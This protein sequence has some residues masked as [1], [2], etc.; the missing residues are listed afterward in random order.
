[1]NK[2]VKKNTPVHPAQTVSEAFD[3]IMKSNFSYLTEWEEA[4]H[5]WQTIEG[6]HQMRVALRRMRSALGLFRF[7]I[8]REHTAHWA[9]D[10]RWLANQLGPARDF[11][12]LITE[13]LQPLQHQLPLA[14]IV[15]LLE[16]AESQ[17]E[18]AYV[19]VRAMLCGERYTT[20]KTNFGQWLYLRGWTDGELSPKQR[21]RLA[22][23]ITPIAK[24]ILNKQ[25]LMVLQTGS[26]IDPQIPTEM[27]QL[28][29]TCKKLRY[30]SEFFEPLFMDMEPFIVH[31]K[32]LQDLLGMLNDIAVMQRLLHELL[33]NHTDRDLL[34]CAGA[35]IGWRTH[36]Y[37]QIKD[38]FDHRWHAFAQACV[39]WHDCVEE[40]ATS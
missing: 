31:L 29:I 15:Q 34:L 16:L 14:G 30:A 32:E 6:V 18:A 9:D 26:T 39:P 11:D 37:A 28:R 40:T 36:Q 12:V 3:V 23:E 19:Q 5:S 20:F 13:S 10:M 25:R 38:S 2:K 33:E 1:M 4:A 8:P 35:L 27:H 21:A 17:R 24:K 22:H 7:A